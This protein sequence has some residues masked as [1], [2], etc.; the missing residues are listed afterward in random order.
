MLSYLHC[1]S[2]FGWRAKTI[3]IRYVWCV[4]FRKRRKKLRFQKHQDASVQGLTR[5]HMGLFAKL[6]TINVLSPLTL[7]FLR[8]LVSSNEETLR[9]F[10][11]FFTVVSLT[12]ATTTL[13]ISL[14]WS[15]Q[16]GFQSIKVIKS[17][18]YSVLL[19]RIALPLRV[20]TQKVRPS[21][22]W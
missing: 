15:L 6:A 8:S 2:V 17:N 11:D 19:D 5:K 18:Y 14:C 7:T 16:T 10:E 9:Q 4:F 13:S 1:F 22:S 21:S 20:P 3:R 12:L